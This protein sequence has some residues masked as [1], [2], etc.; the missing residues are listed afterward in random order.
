[1]A[2]NVLIDTRIRW[3]TRYVYLS[4]YNLADI[5]RLKEVINTMEEKK[6]REEQI[7][8]EVLPSETEDQA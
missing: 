2:C 1:M 4:L 5:K 8:E 7:K 3:N 6:K